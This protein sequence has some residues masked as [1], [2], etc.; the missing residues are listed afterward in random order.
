M[1]VVA[2]LD[3]VQSIF[4]VVEGVFIGIDASHPLIQLLEGLSG[5]LL[6]A[7]L[8]GI[9]H[10]LVGTASLSL[11]GEEHVFVEPTIEQQV[12]LS[13]LDSQA[14]EFSQFGQVSWQRQRDRDEHRF[15][16]IQLVVD[17]GLHQ[18]L[19]HVKGFVVSEDFDV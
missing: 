14:L 9:A 12:V 18:H 4:K 10:P 3:L 16:R 1:H 13:E 17:Q 2:M 6:H 15:H 8:N 11:L 19:L 7:L 5:C